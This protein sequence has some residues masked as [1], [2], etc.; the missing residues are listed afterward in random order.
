MVTMP[1]PRPPHLHK[2]TSRH[3]RT[4]WYVRIGKGPRIRIKAEFGTERF[5]LEY[6][7]AVEGKPLESKRVATTSLQ[8]LWDGYRQTGAWQELSPATRKQRENIML[9][10]LN[11]SGAAPFGAIKKTHVVAGL[12][13]RAKTPAAARNFLDTM[14]G[15]FRWALERELVR[16][17][18]TATVKA[19]KRKKNQGFPAW[20]R[21]D[22]LAYQRR[23]PLGT[24]QRV[25][26]DV[27]LYTG[28][29]RGDASRIGRQHMKQVRGEDGTLMTVAQFKTEK[30]GEMVTVTLPILPPLQRTLEAG[31]IGDLAWIVGARGKPFT[32]ESFGNEFSA[33]ARAAGIKKSAHGVR[34]IAAT[35]AAENGATAHQLMAIFGWTSIRQA[36]VYTREAERSRLAAQAMSKLD[37]TGTAIPSP[38]GVVRARGEKA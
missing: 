10:V 29:R 30:S 34:K 36:E 7:A 35:I 6:G 38:S 23:W 5:K 31:P 28:P 20:T 21:E 13:R 18:P 1:R 11:E 14:K 22:V 26:L 2:E 19:P 8:W 33:A 16:D 17:D 15:L 3:G 24:R 12:D 27:I 37:E 25:W 9:H 32:K 4:V